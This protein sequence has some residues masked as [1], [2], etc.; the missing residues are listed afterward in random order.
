[1]LC[2]YAEC[3]YTDHYA[4]CHILF[5]VILKF[6]NLSVIMLTVIMLNVVMLNVMAPVFVVAKL[7]DLW[8]EINRQRYHCLQPKDCSFSHI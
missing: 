5:I 7:G 6:N 1:M 3:H 2:H 8:R 4:K